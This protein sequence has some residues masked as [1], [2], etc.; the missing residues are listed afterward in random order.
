[1][2]FSHSISTTKLL[3]APLTWLW[4]ICWKDTCEIFEEIKDRPPILMPVIFTL[5]CTVLAVIATEVFWHILLRNDLDVQTLESSLSTLVLVPGILGCWWLISSF[6]YF[7]VARFF[8]V[9]IS[10]QHWVGFTCWS[11]VPLV[12]L[13]VFTALAFVIQTFPL[14]ARGADVWYIEFLSVCC[15]AVPFIWC[16]R[17]AA[18][19]LRTWTAPAGRG[20]LYWRLVAF[21]PHGVFLCIFLFFGVILLT[22]L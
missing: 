13:P 10:W 5:G 21:V 18:L 22:V 12:S 8:K 7:A 19:G 6:Y 9:P 2:Q 16:M 11:S 14:Q 4:K 15:L 20:Y 1:M 17:V 3:H